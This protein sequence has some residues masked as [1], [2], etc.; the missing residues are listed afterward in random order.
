MSE[1]KYYVEGQSKWPVYKVEN[2]ILYFYSENLGGEWLDLIGSFE[3][4]HNK[5]KFTEITKTEAFLK[6]L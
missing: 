6:L 5:S 1:I 3:I 4:F 2:N